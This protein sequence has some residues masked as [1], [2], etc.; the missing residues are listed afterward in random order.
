[1]SLKRLGFCPFA[2]RDK[3]ILPNCRCKPR[4]KKMSK[5]GYDKE[6]YE[7]NRERILERK[8]AEYQEERLALIERL[9][10]R[11]A[12]CNSIENLEIDHI[13]GGGKAHRKTFS[14]YTKYIEFLTTLSQEEL[15]RDY[16]VLCKPHNRSVITDFEEGTRICRRCGIKKPLE[17]FHRN[18][19]RPAGRKYVCKT[20]SIYPGSLL[21]SSNM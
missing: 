1:M 19:T 4:R 13:H 15:E 3:G 17:E 11:C 16:R 10:G 2:M 20:C 14:N 8:K 21:G 12:I 9:G 6:Y 18:K 5:A 7:R